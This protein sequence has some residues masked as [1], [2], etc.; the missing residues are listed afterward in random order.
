MENEERF[1]SSIIDKIEAKNHIN[2]DNIF[3]VSNQQSGHESAVDTVVA[4]QN[5]IKNVSFKKSIVGGYNKQEVNNFVNEMQNSLY[6]F[7]QTIIS[8][9]SQKQFLELQIDQ[10][11]GQLEHFYR[12]ENSIQN[13]LVSAESYATEI[14][15]NA[16]DE[17]EKI[18]KHANENA[19]KI[20]SES[21]NEA[22]KTIEN[23]ETVRKEAYTF[24]ARMKM[25]IQAQMELFD[26]PIEDND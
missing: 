18:V 2:E 22:R 17:A 20:I 14:K 26:E 10:M 9:E 24:R 21:L 16:L 8:V 6:S 7:E 5:Q 23:L 25:M 12:L 13:S 15:E 19:N 1:I 3:P 4:K 11:K